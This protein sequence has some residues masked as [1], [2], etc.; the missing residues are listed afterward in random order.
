MRYP[1]A[2]KPKEGCNVLRLKA[3]LYGL[4]QSGRVWWIQLKEAM[5]AQGFK[6]CDFDWGL[7]VRRKSRHSKP[8]LVMSYVDDLIIA[9]PSREEIDGILKGLRERWEVKEETSVSHILG[10]KIS[11]DR[12]N[13]SFFISQTATISSLY[14]KFPSKNRQK[15]TPLPHADLQSFTTCRSTIHHRRSIIFNSSSEVPRAYWFYSV[16]SRNHKARHRF[17]GIISSSLCSGTE[18]DSLADGF[19]SGIIF[20]ANKGEG[21]NPTWDAR[22][23]ER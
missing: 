3:S 17:F 23:K 6:R 12:Q 21:I 13:R 2:V 1:Q 15:S 4:K 5:I 8:T 20:G 11:R 9:A 19:E 18:R 7:Y 14:D 22:R 16:V 10:I